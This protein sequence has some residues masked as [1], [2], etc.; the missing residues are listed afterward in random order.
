MK[1]MNACSYR[2]FARGG[3]FVKS[4]MLISLSVAMLLAGLSS[5]Q[6]VIQ[7][8]PIP[9]PSSGRYLPNRGEMIV[10]QNEMR[11]VREGVL[12]SWRPLSWELPTRVDS[13]LW[14]TAEYQLMW[15]P[16]DTLPPLVTTSPAGTPR[17]QAGVLGNA[18]TSTLFGGN[19]VNDDARSGFRLG[20]GYWFNPQQS[21]GIEAGFMI[22]QNK[23]AS[24]SAASTDGTILARPFFNPDALTQQSVLVAFPGLSNGT[25]DIR[26]RSGSFYEGHINLAENA[27]DNDWFRLYS[28]I[29]YRFYRYDESL[30]IN[31]T[32]TP[33][34]PLFIAG[35]T[36]TTSDRFSTRNEF[37]GLD[38]G[39]RSE[40][41]WDRFSLEVLTKLAAGRLVR[42]IDINGDQ[43]IAVPGTALVEQTGGLYASTTNIG[44][45]SF[46]DW[47]VMPEVG[48]TLNYQIMP[49]TNLRVGYSFLLLQSI[50]RASEQIDTNVNPNFLP[51]GNAAFGGEKLPAFRNI[52]SDQW[53]QTVNV[54]LEFRY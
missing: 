27:Y 38:I 29:G 25:I 14:V 1:E 2:G 52:S 10:P 13:S 16:G 51:G 50:S 44:R 34:D 31:Q 24:F 21:L 4:Q 8:P 47:K 49:N 7:T 37:H 39:F 6:E 11:G 22:V 41:F 19:T 48:I 42:T 20:A 9:I 43:T 26:A 15:M 32:I 45:R 12:S 3:A 30:N 5:A 46:G 40:F 35:T 36:I 28:M 33:T 53:I 17:L 23:T 18:S 54:G